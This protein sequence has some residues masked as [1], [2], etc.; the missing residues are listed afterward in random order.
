MVDET[1]MFGFEL[2][3]SLYDTQIVKKEDVLILFVHWYFVKNG[4][5]CIGLGDS[6]AY[7]T[8]EK[9]SELLPEGWNTQPIYALRYVNDKKLY[10]FHGVKSDE[11]LLLNLLRMNDQNVS[12][13][14][15][16][17]NATISNLHGPLESVMPPYQNVLQTIQT[18]LVEP[19][20][21]PNTAEN[22]TQTATVN[23]EQRVPRETDPLRVPSTRPASATSPWRPDTDPRNVGSADLNPLA[24]GGGMI[25]DLF[26][27]ERRRPH[28]PFRP[29]LGVPG[30]LPPGAVPPYA[31]FDPFGPPDIDRPR[32]RQGQD[33]D[34]LPPPG[35]DD[36]FM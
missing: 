29:A 6:K 15:F 2:L 20:L 12:N 7:D 8:S 28:N 1:E 34:H 25:Y 26:P 22:S 14:Q 27:P 4:F 13:A 21:P 16:P 23:T 17:I 24:Q 31:R 18:N 10:I 30:V 3:Q 33:N 5:R 9:G 35:Y 19:I 11:D 32:P 36:M